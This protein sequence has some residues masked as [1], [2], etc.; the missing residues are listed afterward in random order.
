MND[1][2][3]KQAIRYKDGFEY[4]TGINTIFKREIIKILNCGTNYN[5]ILRV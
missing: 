5:L 2:L 1:K 3:I 4:F